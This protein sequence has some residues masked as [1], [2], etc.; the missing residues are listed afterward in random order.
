MILSHGTSL[1][2]P[3][4]PNQFAIAINSNVAESLNLSVPD[5]ATLRRAM[6]ASKEAR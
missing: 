4:G 2:A 3:T 5:E 6:L 1:P